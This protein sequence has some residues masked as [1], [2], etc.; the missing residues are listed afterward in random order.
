MNDNKNKFYWHHS[1]KRKTKEN[2]SPS[3]NGEGKQITRDVE[4]AAV[5]NGPFPPVIV[6]KVC[7]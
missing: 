2:V 6:D 4:K 7:P 5:F 1:S 3:P